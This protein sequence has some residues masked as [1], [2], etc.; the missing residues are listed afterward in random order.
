MDALASRLVAAGAVV[1]GTVAGC[2]DDDDGDYPIAPQ[3]SPSVSSA[4]LAGDPPSIIGRVCRLE[5]LR[6]RTSCAEV[7]LGGL[8]VT[9]GDE[10]ATT[11]ADGTFTIA[12]P[13]GSLLSFGVSGTGVIPTTTPFSPSSSV[14][15]VDADVFAR[16][17]TSNGILLPPDTGSIIGTVTRGGLAAVGVTVQSS[18][19]SAFGPFFDGE[20][21]TTLGVVETGEFGAIL[22]PG[23]SSG[24][25]SLT[26]SDQAGSFQTVVDGVRVEPGGVTIL[27]AALPTAGF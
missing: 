23:L 21:S 19:I 6:D 13:A 17:F 27:E 25:T 26:F 3:S 7:G 11:R 15:A 18:P 14:P 24:S 4:D 2:A 20:T 5:D 8:V 9:L 12:R 22:I 10:V 1:L 16:T